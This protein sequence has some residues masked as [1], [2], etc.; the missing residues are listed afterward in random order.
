MLNILLTGSGYTKD[1]FNQ[2]SSLGFKIIHI[3]EDI[4]HD[5][6]IEALPKLDSY[7]LGGNERLTED[8]LAI[9]NKLR[10]ISFVGT[11]FTSFIDEVSAKKRNIVIKNTPEVMAPAVVE[12]TI[13]LLLGLQ[14][15][16]F[17][18]NYDVKN[19][20]ILSYTSDELSSLRIGIVGMGAIGSR[21]AKIL[22]Q[23]FGSRILYHSRTRKKI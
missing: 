5:Y 4:S 22:N 8:K 11:G 2:L 3:N 1:H 18:Q 7:V 23:A 21:L 17:Q 15:K 20:N 12:H 6:L 14:R 13:G 19:S 10:L 16:L 9:A